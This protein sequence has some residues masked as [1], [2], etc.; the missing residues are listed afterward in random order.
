[1]RSIR[2]KFTLVLL[3]FSLMIIVV[4]GISSRWI[5]QRDFTRLVS[6]RAMSGFLSEVVDYYRAY[7]SWENAGATEDFRT[8]VGR[9]RGPGSNLPR[10]RRPGPDADGP[11]ENRLG[12]GA[13]GGPENR[14]RLRN[15]NGPPGR[16][17]DARIPPPIAVVDANGK[18]L[19]G[20]L[21]DLK[22]GDQVAASRMKTASPIQVDNETIG[23]AVVMRTPALTDVEQGYLSA[24]Q[25]AWWY[26]LIVAVSVAVPIGIFAGRQITRPVSS[27]H[28]A[29]E[30]IRDGNMEQYVLV[31]SNDELGQ[32]TD[33][34]NQMSADLASTYRMLQDMT[35][36]D[37]LTQLPNRRAFEELSGKLIAQA[38]RYGQRLTVAIMDIDCFKQI[39][40]NFS[41]SVGDQVLQ[42][43][44]GLLQASVRKMD[45]ISRYGGEEFVF[46]FPHTSLDDGHQLSEK[47]RRHIE[48]C[49]WEHI[50]EGLR[51][52]I[53]FGLAEHAVDGDFGATMNRAD[54]KL[55]EAKAGGRNQV[56]S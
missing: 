48:T 9:T 4:M 12:P 10:L 24:M 17:F 39:N 54:G 33:A 51:V 1:M 18:V 3:L 26:A 37:E 13:A 19:L 46:L 31:R 55:Y 35:L 28:R 50:A 34:F 45:V 11:V 40:D 30:A 7:G 23:Y 38:Q 2:F 5:F 21:A 27:L 41:H 29:M 15:P 49:N 22:V 25:N 56:C 32:L 8:F 47:L 16:A 44:S 36:T 6:E 42:K 52:T 14:P 43:L 53:S 20:G